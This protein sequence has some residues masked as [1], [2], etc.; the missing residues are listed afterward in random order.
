MTIELKQISNGMSQVSK[1]REQ[2]VMNRFFTAIDRVIASQSKEQRISAVTW[3]KLWHEQVKSS[4][5]QHQQQ[6]GGAI[7]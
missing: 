4:S 5:L 2:Y 1:Y 7:D 3:A 6:N